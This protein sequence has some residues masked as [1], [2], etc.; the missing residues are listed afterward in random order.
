MTAIEELR[1]QHESAMLDAANEAESPSGNASHV[2]GHCR[3][4]IGAQDEMLRIINEKSIADS[5]P[6]SPEWSIADFYDNLNRL[7]RRKD[8]FG[9]R[10][11]LVSEQTP[12]GAPVGRIALKFYTATSVYSIRAREAT[13]AT[14]EAEAA[15]S[16]LGCQ[17]SGRTPLPGVEGTGG[18]DLADG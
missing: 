14:P 7:M 5:A 9:R 12:T 18:R 4:A 1:V 15:S 17:V 11:H 16:Y 2:L 8:V 13:E 6:E 3:R 10:Y